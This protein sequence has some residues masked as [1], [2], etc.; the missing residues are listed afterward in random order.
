MSGAQSF[1][2]TRGKFKVSLFETIIL[3]PPVQ[4]SSSF[5]S[6]TC[7][8]GLLLAELYGHLSGQSELPAQPP[9]TPEDIPVN[10]QTDFRDIKGQEH[11]KRALDVASAGGH[12]VIVLWAKDW[13]ILP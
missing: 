1:I 9:I 11:V 6:L 4:H 7:R 12:N 10:V 13:S 8:C 2:L 5:R 3:A